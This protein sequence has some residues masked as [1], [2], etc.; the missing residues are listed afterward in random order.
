LAI[1]LELTR[2]DAARKK[3]LTQAFSKTFLLVA[4]RPAMRHLITKYQIVGDLANRFVAGEDVPQAVEA[5]R[6][7]NE[8]GLWGLVNYLGENVATPQQATV[9]ADT[10]I[11]LLQRISSS[12][13]I[14]SV[15]VKVTQL[16]L[17]LGEDVCLWNLTRV[18]DAARTCDCYVMLDME[19]SAYTDA[20]I[21]VFLKLR[22]SYENLGICLQ[23][24]LYRTEADLQDMVERDVRIRLCKGAYQEPSTVA[25]REKKDVDANYLKLMEILLEHGHYPAIATHDERIIEH[26]RRFATARG[27]D[28]S[29]FEFQML[30]GVRR[31]LQERLVDDGY[32]VRVY[33]PFGREWYPYLVRRLAERPANLM[34]VLSNVLREAGAARR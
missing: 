16:G 34:F 21:S 20:T 12:H 29:R 13:L 15:S 26:A 3:M 25:F 33:V 11:D 22:R 30:Y 17:D 9:D 10:Y 32:R 14:S 18:L 8:R 19:G 28:S 31:D 4:N 7:L 6:R 27:L 24:Y 5:V 23:A 2:D 1:T